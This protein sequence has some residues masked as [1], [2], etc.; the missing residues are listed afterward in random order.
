[1]NMPA[2]RLHHESD[3]QQLLDGIAD[4]PAIRISGITSDSRK[5][6][7]GEL[8][9]A[10]A[11]I[12]S[13]GLDYLEQAIAAGAAAVIHDGAANLSG[14]MPADIPIVCV[15]DL[16]AQQGIIADRWFA[17]PSA[18]LRVAGVTGTNGKTTVAYL[19]AQCLQMLNR[20]C[21]YVGTLGS[22]IAELDASSG[23][24]T[25]ACIDLHR[26]LA[27]F[28]DGGAAYVALEVSSHALV[29]QRVGGVRFDAALFTN[30]SRDHI[31]YHGDMAAYGE[32]KA[33]LFL[34]TSARHRIVNVDTEFG[35][36]LADRCGDDTI[37]VS[38][39]TGRPG[40]GRAYVV[41]RSVVAQ[42][43]GSIVSIQS[44]WGDADFMLPLVGEFNVANALA[45]FALLLCW[46]I[47]I[48]QA[49]D[50]LE[51][52]HAPPGRMQKVEVDG[53]AAL[54]AVYVDYA[55]TPD[56]LEVA[57]RA[58]RSHCSGQ[59]WCVF[60]CGG[61]RDQGKRPLMGEVVSDR[62][63]RAVVT[64]DNPRSEDPAQIIGEVMSA[65]GE[66]AIAIEDRASA[67]AWTIANAQADDIV[68]IAGKGHE[69]TQQIGDS[70]QRFSDYE[71]A[72]SN[73]ASRQ[74]A[75]AAT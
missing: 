28:R 57:L 45:V 16:A 5:L 58:L 46:G 43:D 13:H 53:D 52:V 36:R 7:P 38:T 22:G 70:L 19:I 33:K 6:Q 26:L 48:V 21:A 49:A 35:A 56:A 4:A 3:L 54:P 75:G 51:G 55:H 24:T 25:P 14:S 71:C 64:N 41:L 74:E 47:P 32:A 18:T 63:D 50:V 11:G 69:I 9:I 66:N 68:L 29:Q 27:D 62:A 59:L 15:P 40:N 44:S 17:S 65:M 61:D 1:M 73:L 34:E 42:H 67:I 37:V 60:G 39:D 8:F 31:D 2:E 20:K 72:L 12:D 23:M 10:V 30:L